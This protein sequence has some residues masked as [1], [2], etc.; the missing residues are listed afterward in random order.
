MKR[1]IAAFAA[2]LVC[3]SA[4]AQAPIVGSWTST[5][6]ESESASEDGVDADIKMEGIDNL[7]FA[8][9]GTYFHEMIAIVTI[10]G[11]KDGKTM[12]MGMTLTASCTGSWDNAA[13]QLV[14]TPDKKAKPKVE[15][16][17]DGFPAILKVLLI[18]PLKSELKKAIKETEYYKII[19]VSDK[20]L[21]LKDM[22]A[23]G[24]KKPSK[25]ED[26]KTQTYTR[27]L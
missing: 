25:P 18:N 22:D 16:K 6:K 3:L 10:E 24:T 5:D 11:S 4:L 26:L 1:L 14:L 8:A 19:S 23:P 15:V 12:T 20:Q 2:V 21:V 17:S 7:R 9:D 27:V 13:G